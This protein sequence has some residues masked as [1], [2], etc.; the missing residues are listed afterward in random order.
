MWGTPLSSRDAENLRRGFL[1]RSGFMVGRPLAAPTAVAG[2]V[3]A[4]AQGAR[5][6]ED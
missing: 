5:H 2:P 6:D 1:I 3:A 4:L